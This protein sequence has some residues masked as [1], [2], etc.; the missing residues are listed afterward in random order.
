MGNF[1]FFIF[2]SGDLV[3]PLD[4]GSA[5]KNMVC[6]YFLFILHVLNGSKLMSCLFLFVL[7]ALSLCMYL[8]PTN[9]TNS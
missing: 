3:Q 8:K 4:G 1:I 2:Q 9:Q 5:E 6:F 7:I